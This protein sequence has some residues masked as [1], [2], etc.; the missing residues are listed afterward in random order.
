VFSDPPASYL[1]RI[2]QTAHLVKAVDSSHPST[3][4]VEVAS[5][6]VVVEQRSSPSP[7]PSSNGPVESAAGPVES[8][9]HLLN[10]VDS[11]H[12]ST[13]VVETQQCWNQGLEDWAASLINA[14]DS[15]PPSTTV[16][17][18]SSPPVVVEQWALSTPQYWSQGLEEWASSLVNAVDSSHPSA[19]VV[20]VPS[21]PDRVAEHA[22]SALQLS[23]ELSQSLHPVGLST[24]L[25]NVVAVSSPA[26]AI[27]APLQQ[28]SVE[29]VLTSTNSE[30]SKPAQPSFQRLRVCESGYEA[31]ALEDLSSPSQAKF[32]ASFSVPNSA[33]SRHS[34]GMPSNVSSALDVERPLTT[35]TAVARC[36]VKVQGLS[37]TS[38]CAKDKFQK[39]RFGMQV[40]PAVGL[41]SSSSS[42]SSI[43]EAASMPFRGPGVSIKVSS[44]AN[45]VSSPA[46][47]PT[48]DLLKR[49]TGV[50][51]PSLVSR[52]ASSNLQL[53]S[54][55]AG[56]M[57]KKAVFHEASFDG[58]TETSSVRISE[59]AVR[60][61]K[62]LPL[63]QTHSG[64]LQMLRQV[65]DDNIASQ[66][67]QAV[68]SSTD[69]VGKRSY[70]VTVTR[71]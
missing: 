27:G 7:E 1:Q 32:N 40:R 39:R 61:V 2:E 4:A 51:I 69:R 23:S 71:T 43:G 53:I 11:S 65:T 37:D 67:Q 34:A 21:R 6:P 49:S 12:P 56:H 36:N 70:G 22:W 25:A 15:G 57:S 30:I 14:V 48:L 18:V 55:V 58:Q 28:F 8:T 64:G 52:T 59:S 66:N 54:S 29:H 44:N 26:E 38:S 24:C 10:A 31:D 45:R 50:R 3:I 20:E 41:Q 42:K 5:Q 16:V 63:E 68:R 60:H 46:A 17:E 35:A 19:T 47:V 33:N 13:I 62:P 9:A